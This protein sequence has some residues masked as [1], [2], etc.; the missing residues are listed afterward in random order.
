MSYPDDELHISS[1]RSL[2]AALRAD[3]DDA[4]A[5]IAKLLEVLELAADMLM[6]HEP[7]DSRAV[8]DAAVAI[9]CASI[10]T[11][12]D[13]VMVVVRAAN[14]A[15]KNRCADHATYQERSIMPLLPPASDDHQVIWLEPS[16]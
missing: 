7:G 9:C 8:S 10:G 16:R 5:Q 4:R 15:A 2:I 12:D 13:Q 1:Q 3:R 11:T 6:E 14:A